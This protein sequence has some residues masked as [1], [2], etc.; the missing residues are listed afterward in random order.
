MHTTP[1]S[2]TD[3]RPRVVRASGPGNDRLRAY[4]VR[5]RHVQLFRRIEPEHGCHAML[6]LITAGLWLV[7]WLSVVLVARLS[8]W[9]CPRCEWHLPRAVALTARKGKPRTSANDPTMTGTAP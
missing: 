6:T 7:S 9:R 4:C 3:Y 2:G 8:P 5:C 1:E